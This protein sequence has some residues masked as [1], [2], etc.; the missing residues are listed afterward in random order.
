MSADHP[1][2][3]RFALWFDELESGAGL[4]VLNAGPG[5]GHWAMECLWRAD[6]CVWLTRTGGR[7]PDRPGA[8]D[9]LDRAG[10]VFEGSGRSPRWSLVLVHPSTC[11]RPEG[12]RRWLEA[13]PFTRHLHV[14][15]DDC[16]TAARAARLL[17]GRGFGLALSG[18][19][20]RG[21]AHIGVLR[22]L[23]ELSIPVD[24]IGGTS[25]G[26]IMAAQYCVAR[27]ID[28]MIAMNRRAMALR[29]FHQYTVPMVALNDPAAAER[30]VEE[31]FGETRIEDLW[32]PCFAVSADLTTCSMVVHER[33]LLRRAA[34]ATSSLP[35]VLVPV[36][37]DGHL[38]V[39]GGI[40]N[41]I[42]GDLVKV[43]AGGP[44]LAVNASP[45]DELRM[46]RPDFP[47][48]WS[49]LWH[50]L[51]PWL[52]RH[53]VPLLGDI[54]MRTL[55]TASVERTNQIRESVD[56]FLDLPVEKFGMLEF[57]AIEE[58]VALGH[59]HACERLAAWPLRPGA[60]AARTDGAEPGAAA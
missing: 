2:W 39:D 32:R 30:G 46:E 55:M 51:L 45:E 35:G 52:K 12:T 5:A 41:N 7:S 50:R 18:G 20:A 49:I 28:D 8:F 27:S 29:P 43:R 34:R 36:V 10:R 57:E 21:F 3:G 9:S 33:G 48:Q 56:V 44:V 31:T 54:L 6:S 42:P 11:E 14:R 60:D 24:V 16:E 22:A 23:E 53:D 1:V 25:I 58:L 47:S 4:M 26:G 19:G 13:R 38:L 17:T 40:I 15:L 37:E 59:A